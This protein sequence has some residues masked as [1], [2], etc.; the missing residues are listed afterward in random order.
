LVV[1]I[2]LL[3]LIWYFIRS[4]VTDPIERMVAGLRSIVSGDGD[5]TQRLEVRGKDELGQASAV[6]NEMMVK[7]SGLVQQVSKSAE[8][9]A[10]AARKLV[11]N[12]EA[13]AGSSRSQNDTSTEA[14]RSVEQIAT[15]IASVAQH[16]GQVRE[17]SRESL[18]RSDEGKVSLSQLTDAVGIVESTVRDIAGSV[19]NFVSS[20]EAINH[21]TSQVKEIADQT[22][23]LALNAAIEA[24]RAGEH[25]R[26]FAVV[27]DEVRKLAEKS[28]ASANE[29]AGITRTLSQQ[30]DE[31]TRAINDAMVHIATSRE[32]VRTVEEV[33]AAASDSVAD[34]GKGLDSIAVATSEQTRAGAEVATGIEKIAAMARDNS[35]AASQTVDAAHSLEALAEEQQGTVGRF[36]T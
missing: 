14:A 7:F 5:L 22:N 4:A 18:R 2:L 35:A 27:A 21:I 20:T 24:A 33:L 29:I 13:V 26:G 25:G 34:V 19:G 6:F 30:S 8:Q 11:S 9:V 1:S 17:R 10:A 16:A 3:G 23:L 15:S 28:A 36:K 31:V 32:S 12:A